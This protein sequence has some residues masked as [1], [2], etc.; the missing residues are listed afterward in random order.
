M[1]IGR[2]RMWIFLALVLSCFAGGGGAREDLMSLLYVRPAAVICAALILLTP[3][4]IDWRS[5]RVPLLLCL[6]FAALMGIQLIPLP[7]NVWMSLPGR[8]LFAEAMNVAG[9]PQPWRPLSIAPDRTLNSL[10]AMVVPIATL[11]GFAAL[12]RDRRLFLLPVLIAAALVSVLFGLAQLASGD[13]SAFYLYRVTNRDSAVGLFANRNHQAALLAVTFPMLAIWAATRKRAG[14][15][16][17]V[18]MIITAALAVFLVPMVLVTG[19][20]AGL[21][22]GGI[23]AAAACLLYVQRTGSPDR[24]IHT[25]RGVALGFGAIALAGLAFSFAAFDRAESLRRLLQGDGSEDL[26]L[27]TIGPV[28]ELARNMMPLGSGFGTFDPLYRIHEPTHLLTPLYL[29][30]AHND[31]LE[32]AITGGIPALLLLAIGL[33]WI[34]IGGVK[35]CRSWYATSTQIAYGRLGLVIV[36]L[37]LAWS[38]VDYPLR[39]PSI[40]MLFSIA[41]A[42]LGMGRD[43]G[44]GASAAGAG[45]QPSGRES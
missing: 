12:D 11:I 39:T 33:V 5:V 6:A 23:A 30:H 3:G 34:A 8:E 13:S 35:V 25:W 37:F 7:P 41:S 38:L 18:S 10:A 31:L 1:M 17:S 16:T 45:R 19:S 40:A 36:V 43:R 29:N 14:R 21:L 15:A 32:L 9:L 26:R 44:S 24:K 27:E 20:R 28:T 4:R 2:L 22:F 42:W